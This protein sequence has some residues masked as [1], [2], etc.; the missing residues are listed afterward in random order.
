VRA[1]AVSPEWSEPVVAEAA[2]SWLH[3]AP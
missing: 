1:A 3:A 2:V